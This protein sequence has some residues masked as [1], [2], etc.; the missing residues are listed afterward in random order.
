[1]RL[2]NLIYSENLKS[3]SIAKTAYST[4]QKKKLF[5]EIKA[6]RG[7]GVV[8]KKKDAVYIPGRPASGGD[9]LKFKF[10]A[11]A[12][13][14]VLNINGSKRSVSI[15]VRNDNPDFEGPKEIQ[16]GNVT[17]L[18]N[19]EIP[20]PGELIEVEYLYSYPGGALYQP[21]YKGPRPD[22]DTAD[23]YSSLKFKQGTLEED[24]A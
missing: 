17:I 8:F 22:K 10:K 9:C 12:T 14:R 5:Y 15:L 13:C 21:I 7:E 19:F 4:E 2:D 16:V 23:L 1:M 3:V 18:P 24:I 20:T 6:A 11:S